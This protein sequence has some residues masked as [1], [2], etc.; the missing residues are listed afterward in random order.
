MSEIPKDKPILVY[1]GSGYRSATGA[2]IIQQQLPSVKVY[3]L[4][5]EVSQYIKAHPPK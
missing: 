5:K 1:C 2:S 4:S 3:D